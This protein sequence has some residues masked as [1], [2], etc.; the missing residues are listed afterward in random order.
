MPTNTKNPVPNKIKPADKV[1][2][3]KKPVGTSNTNK[4]GG[5][6]VMGGAPKDVKVEETKATENI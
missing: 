5:K 3:E 6:V 2:P 1:V 4:K